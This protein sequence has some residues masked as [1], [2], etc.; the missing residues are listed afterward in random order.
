MIARIA[1]EACTDSLFRCYSHPSTPAHAV[2]AYT[3]FDRIYGTCIREFSCK[4]S[5]RARL[6]KTPPRPVHLH[7]V[8]IRGQEVNH[9]GG[10]A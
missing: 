8:I 2:H 3:R 5:S 9:F 6:L 10:E 4:K 7:R 1:K